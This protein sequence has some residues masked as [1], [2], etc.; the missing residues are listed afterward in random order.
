MMV[1]IS[2]PIALSN[3]KLVKNNQAMTP[4]WYQAS[5]INSKTILH[6]ALMDTKIN[7]PPDGFDM[8]WHVKPETW[9][10]QT[11][12]NPMCHM[13]TSFTNNP[14]QEKNL[15]VDFVYPKFTCRIPNY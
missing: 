4:D 15:V 9:Q 6:D 2:F 3:I 1:N 11:M 7:C 13:V 5:I 14:P 10:M 12:R 8:K